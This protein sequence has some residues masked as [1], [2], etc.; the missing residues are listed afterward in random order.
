[1]KLDLGARE[2]KRDDEGIRE[3]SKTAAG[4]EGEREREREEKRVYIIV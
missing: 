1:L 4:L 3:R 2:D